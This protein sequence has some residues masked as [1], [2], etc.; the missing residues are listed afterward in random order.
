MWALATARIGGKPTAGLIVDRGFTAFAP[1]DQSDGRGH[2]RRLGNSASRS[3]LA[4]A[5][6]AGT[7][8]PLADIELLAPLHYPGKILCA[9]A[10]YYDHMAEMGFP[11]VK[12]EDP[13]AV[14]FPQAPRNAVVGAGRHGA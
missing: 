3:S 11:D 12:K 14:L 1:P 13:A 4:L 8:T 10:N 5:A 2:I 9:G 6:K 7:G